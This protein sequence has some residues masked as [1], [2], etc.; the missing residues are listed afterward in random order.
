M[1]KFR[2]DACVKR[3]IDQINTSAI[4]MDSVDAKD[5]RD[6]VDTLYNVDARDGV[7][8]RDASGLGGSATIVVF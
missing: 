3:M 5:T 2:R 1:I 7:D 4:S 6:S 8:T